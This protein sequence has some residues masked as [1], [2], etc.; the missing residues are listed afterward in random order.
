M[1]DNTKEEEEREKGRMDMREC[2]RGSN[3]SPNS[4]EVVSFG[5]V[6]LKR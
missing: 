5:E 1:I 2:R 3:S 6:T 4:E